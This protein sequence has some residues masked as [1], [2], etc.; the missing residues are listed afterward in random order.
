M[1]YS[2]PVKRARM[3]VVQQAIDGGNGPGRIELRDSNRVILT[4]LLLTR[5]SFYL[6]GADLQLAAPTTSFVVIEGLATIGT[7]T[8]G[9][10]NI[11]IDE[12]SVGVDNTDDGIHDFEIVLDTNVLELGKQVTIVNATIEHG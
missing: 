6:V 2:Q 5:P 12:M 10:G 9:T 7:I 1:D 11:V 3:T 8:D 4:T